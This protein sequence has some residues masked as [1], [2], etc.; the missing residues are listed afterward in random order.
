MAVVATIKDFTKIQQELRE[1]PK[2]IP[3][4]MS[5][6]INEAIRKSRTT[7]G[8]AVREY[9]NVK[10]SDLN[11]S[12]RMN[13]SSPGSDPHGSLVSEINRYPLFTFGVVARKTDRVV[14]MVRRG[15]RVE[16]KDGFMA[17][18]PTGRVGIFH[19]LGAKQEMQS[20]NYK[21]KMKQPI[22]EMFTG[23]ASEMLKAQRSEEAVSD[24]AY[25]ALEKA[26]ERQIAYW[27]KKGQADRE[28]E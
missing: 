5:R 27:L 26:A 7:T 4:A 8:R 23:A 14:V 11:R 18:M 24:A 22:H 10:L 20:G 15:A 6:A 13:F 3:L 28:E 1:Y 19:R 17:I 9:Y 25:A 21:G 2:A 12:F 16:L